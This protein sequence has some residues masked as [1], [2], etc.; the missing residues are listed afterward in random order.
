MGLRIE[1]G[2]GHSMEHR[3]QGTRELRRY[4]LLV[5]RYSGDISL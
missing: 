4:P 1:E 3:A 5:I 2:I